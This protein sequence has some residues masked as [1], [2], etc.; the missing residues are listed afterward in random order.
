MPLQPKDAVCASVR[1]FGLVSDAPTLDVTGSLAAG[2]YTI[3]SNGRTLSGQFGTLD[4][5]AG[6]TINYGTGNDSSITLSAMPEPSAFV[7][8]GV[9]VVGLPG[10][11][12]GRTPASLPGK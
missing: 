2:P 6:Y 1:Y 5:P 4:I 11:G 10:Y 8:L 7:L 12:L 3:A 9:G